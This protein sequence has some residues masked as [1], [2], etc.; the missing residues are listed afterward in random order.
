MTV[1]PCKANQK[2]GAGNPS[3]SELDK[4]PKEPK[5]QWESSKEGL[6]SLS[7]TVNDKSKS[8]AFLVMRK[9]L[10]STASQLSSAPSDLES[11]ADFE[12]IP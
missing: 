9:M 10:P 7:W 12:Q 11:A 6:L 8:K 1:G 3:Y 2:Q 5:M 4:S